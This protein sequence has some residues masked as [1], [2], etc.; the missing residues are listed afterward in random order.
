MD[1]PPPSSERKRELAELRSRAYGPDADIHLD[2]TALARLVEL[3][4][5][6]RADA[7]NPDENTDAAP[8]GTQSSTPPPASVD[9]AVITSSAAPPDAPTD[10]AAPPRVRGWH[11]VPTWAFVAVAAVVGLGIGLALPAVMPPHPEAVLRSV[12]LDGETIDFSMYGVDASPPTRYAPFRNLEVW[13]AETPGGSACVLVTTDDG[14][15]VAAGCAPQQLEATADLTFYP[16][17]REVEGFDLPDGSVVRFV[18][19]GDSVEVW[20]ASADEA[21]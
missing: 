11:R 7:P 17:M 13:S 9:A 8:A 18:L 5:M 19:I 14:D 10:D 16:G 1:A 2:T 20:I 12:P 6:A 21:A 15:W 4:G 3:E